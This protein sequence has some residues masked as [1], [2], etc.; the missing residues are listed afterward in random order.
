MVHTGFQRIF[1]SGLLFSALSV[2]S[3]AHAA[4]NEVTFQGS[5]VELTGKFPLAGEQAKSFSLTDSDLNEVGL[6]AWAGKRKVLNIMVSADTPVCD[7]SMRRFNEMAAHM[8][9][10]VVL[11]ISSD[12]PF[13][14]KRFCSSA[15]IDHVKTLSTFRSTQFGKDYGVGIAQGPLRNLTARAIVVLDEKNRVLYS[16]LVPEITHEPDYQKVLDV[17]G[18]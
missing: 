16:Q 10:T 9:N 3:A 8:K 6:D 12:L 17:L 1:W 4:K 5:R 13:A 11:G 18:K 15:G 2:A 14:Q 7:A